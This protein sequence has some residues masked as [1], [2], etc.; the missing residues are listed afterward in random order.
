MGI[1]LVTVALVAALVAPATAVAGDHAVPDAVL[2]TA[3][4]SEA[5]S[6]AEATW[7]TRSGDV[8]STAVL[9]GEYGFPSPPVQWVPGTEIAVRFEKRRRPL[10]VAASA[11]LV[12]DPLAGVPIYGEVAIPHEMRR[13]KVDGKTMWEAVLSPP[14]WP[15]LYM[16]VE[17]E[18]DGS[19]GCGARRVL[20]KWRAGLLPL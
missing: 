13:V 18:W 6:L 5:G 1:K 10:V 14:P 12:G 19:G 9:D 16:E 8:C 17:A 15:D 11:F 7:T 20:W 3:T 4:D 2:V